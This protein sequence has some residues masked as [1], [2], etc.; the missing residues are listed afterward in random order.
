MTLFAVG[1]TWGV[2]SSVAEFVHVNRPAT[3]G[4]RWPKEAIIEA[5]VNIA[6]DHA[7]KGKAS[8]SSVVNCSFGVDKRYLPDKLREIWRKSTCIGSTWRT[9]QKE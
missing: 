2:A 9:I 3:I 5:F 1:K 6:N 4:S 7:S 8:H